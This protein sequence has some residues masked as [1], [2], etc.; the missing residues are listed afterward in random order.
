MVCFSFHIKQLGPVKDT[1][2]DFDGLTI[3]TGDNGTGKTYI[4][5]AIFSFFDYFKPGQPLLQSQ[6][7]SDSSEL[8]N[9]SQKDYNKLQ[10]LWIKTSD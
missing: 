2:V 4:A 9:Y 3:L 8:L 7:S 6:H 5:S 1:T 10:S